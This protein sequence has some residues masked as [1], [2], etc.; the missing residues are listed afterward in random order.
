MWFCRDPRISKYCIISANNQSPEPKSV[1]E[2]VCVRECVELRQCRSDSHARH[3]Q[4]NNTLWGEN[5][6]RSG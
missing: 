2:C 5:G 4:M 1:C 6:E 3:V